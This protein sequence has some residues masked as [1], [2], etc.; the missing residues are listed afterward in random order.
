MLFF[1]LVFIP[2]PSLLQF[3]F[4]C[5]NPKAALTW[6]SFQMFL[7]SHSCL[8]CLPFS[9]LSVPFLLCYS[10]L[11]LFLASCRT[12]VIFRTWAIFFTLIWKSSPLWFIL[13]SSRAIYHFGNSPQN[14]PVSLKLN[15]ACLEPINRH[16]FPQIQFFLL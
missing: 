11:T 2:F 15:I 16:P 5:F 4:L 6:I 3:L 13:G 10:F 7:K 14:I 9:P 12:W 1:S 8:S